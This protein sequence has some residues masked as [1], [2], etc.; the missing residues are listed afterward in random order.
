MKC[1][2]FVTGCNLYLFFILYELLLH[3]MSLNRN[4]AKYKNNSTSWF[5][6]ASFMY[7]WTDIFNHP[8][9]HFSPWTAAASAYLS[10]SPCQA[11]L[12]SL[13]GT[14]CG[15]SSTRW[16][17]L[18]VVVIQCVWH[19][20]TDTGTHTLTHAHTH[21]P[22]IRARST[23]CPG[24]PCLSP[25]QGCS[26]L[27]TLGSSPGFHIQVQ[28]QEAGA[29]SWWCAEGAWR[30][31]QQMNHHGLIF[32]S[33]FLLPSSISPSS[34]S[35]LTT[36]LLPPSISPSPS[37]AGKLAWAQHSYTIICD[38][39]ARGCSFFFIKHL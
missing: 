18:R 23:T 12:P 21:S 39:V 7:I 3:L 27:G 9:P 30:L 1:L 31:L 34:P 13:G 28:G 8:H 33:R 22:I 29:N 19:T 16:L 24:L 17:D 20:H 35:H 5:N 32:N 10:T 25:S 2:I 15:D 4:M 37:P 11:S 38:G 14:S 26:W 36:F 6:F